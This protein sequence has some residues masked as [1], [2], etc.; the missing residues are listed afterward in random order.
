MSRSYKHTPR[1]GQQKNKFCKR[2]ANRRLRRLPIDEPPLNNRS[3]RKHY[4]YYDICDYETV[5]T[6]FEQ[7]WVDLVK[8]WHEW[9]WQYEPY[10]DREKAYQEYRRWFIRK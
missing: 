3:Y 4:C 5:G 10:P 1:S 9:L 7:Y 8:S 2:Y 6:S